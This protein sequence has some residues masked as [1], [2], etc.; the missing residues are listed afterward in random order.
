MSQWLVSL[1]ERTKL[2]RYPKAKRGPKKPKTRRTRFADKT[3]IATSRLLND[4][5]TGRSERDGRVPP[6][7]YQLPDRWEVI[8]F[9]RAPVLRLPLRRLGALDGDTLQGRLD[10][11]HIGSV[12][13]GH[14]QTHRHPTA[15]GQNRPRG[16]DLG[17]I[18]GVLAR[19]LSP[20]GA[21]QQNCL[22]ETRQ[23]ELPR[24]LACPVSIRSNSVAKP[25]EGSL[26]HGPVEALP[27]P[28]D[29]DPV[30][31]LVEGGLP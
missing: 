4:G 1:A 31:V 20:R 6:S 22:V 26:G 16:A 12:G 27:V 7:G 15:V 24:R 5:Q 13:P 28:F 17:P 30:V 29:A 18:R 10:Q 19:L 11:P 2:S 23:V 9:I 25:P 21:L 3:H 14:L 8:P